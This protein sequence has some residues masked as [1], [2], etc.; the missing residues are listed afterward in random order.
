MQGTSSSPPSATACLVLHGN[1]ACLPSWALKMGSES[2]LWCWWNAIVGSYRAWVEEW[3]SLAE[4][5][6]EAAVEALLFLQRAVCMCVAVPGH[7]NCPASALGKGCVAFAL[8]YVV[9]VNVPGCHEP[10][11]SSL[12]SS[13]KVWVLQS[14]MLTN[15]PNALQSNNCR[16]QL[17][18]VNCWWFWV[19][20]RVPWRW[21]QPCSSEWKGRKQVA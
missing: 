4:E 9:R 16:L 18:V 20:A 19:Q 21:L 15:L 14:H 2:S 13:L 11:C 12:Q 6:E 10:G 17:L 7:S 8:G 5:E 1:S 3:S